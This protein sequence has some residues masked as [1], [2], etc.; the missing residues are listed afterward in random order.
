MLCPQVLRNEDKFTK[1][2]KAKRHLT[3]WSVFRP[4][5]V[6]LMLEA[7]A[8]Y[9]ATGLRDGVEELQLQII[10]P[11]GNLKA[12]AFLAPDPDPTMSGSMAQLVERPTT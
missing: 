4:E 2:S 3:T 10:H 5:T 6:D 12:L 9:R 11:I 8:R 1:R 7:R